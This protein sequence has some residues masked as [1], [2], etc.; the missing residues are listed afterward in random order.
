MKKTNYAF[1]AKIL[2]REVKNKVYKLAK[3]TLKTLL[4]LSAS[5]M[6]LA[7]CIPV[8][9]EDIN[10]DLF[11]NKEA[12]QSAVERLRPGMTKDEVMSELKIPIERF[13]TMGTEELQK[14]VY[15][16][17]LVQ[18]TPEQLERFKEILLRYKGYCLPY[19]NLESKGSIGFGKM[20][21]NKK[22]YDVK[23]VILFEN[24]IL[25]KSS[26]DGSQDVNMNENKYIWNTLMEKGSG[27]AF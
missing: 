26:I 3:T 23:L 27:A 25:L 2:A 18:G 7:T 9:N 21:V 20:R 12:M 11:E 6:L 13:T 24:N 4:I 1:S 19:R 22:G 8:G 10:T 17:S 15:G 14:N 16:N 5:L